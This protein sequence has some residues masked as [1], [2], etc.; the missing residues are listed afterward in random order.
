MSTRAAA[1]CDHADQLADLDVAEVPGQLDDRQR[2][3]HAR[4]SRARARRSQARPR[5][6]CSATTP[7]STREE[8]RRRRSAVVSR[9]SETRTL[10]WVSTPI[11]ASTWLGSSVDAVQAE[12]LATANPRRSSSVTSASPSTYRQEN[13]TRWGSRSTGSPTTS[14]SGTSAATAVRIRSTSACWRAFDLVA[15]GDHGL[16]RGGGGQGG[17]HVLEAGARARRPGRRSGKGLRHRAPLRTSSTPTPAGPPHLCAEPAAA[18][19]PSGSGEPAHRGAGVDEERVRRRRPRGDLGDRL[20]GAD[21][22]VGGLAGGDATSGRAARPSHGVEARPGPV[23]GHRD[24]P[25]ASARQAGGVQHRRVLDG[26]VD[27]ASTARAGARAQPEQPAVH[28]VGAA[29]A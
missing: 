19:S 7:G 24:R 22:V 17:R 14:T 6:G 2:A 29:T 4:G 25:S 26:G 8:A 28:R 9:A 20:E 15:L 12:P 23:D 21:L 10:P 3:A 1:S 27:D 16:E 5:R 11:A 13:V 18:A